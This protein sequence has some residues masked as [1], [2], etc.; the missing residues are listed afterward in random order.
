M[1]EHAQTRAG[2]INFSMDNPASPATTPITLDAR[3]V[4][5]TMLDHLG[6]QTKVD[7][8]TQDDAPLLHI[9]TADPDRLIGRNGQTLDQLQFLL[10]RILQR[11]NPDAPRVIVDCERYRERERDELIKKAL[12][13]VDR[14]R[15]WGDSVTI[16][17]YS[18]FDRRI[19][20]RHIERDPELEAVSEG[21]EDEGGRKRMIIRAKSK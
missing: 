2:K 17:P 3:I 16:G 15:R 13:A 10:N 1:V 21:N 4:L 6:L 19:I 9:A 12:D 5:Q 14:V 7:Q 20:H 8:F 18:P 11:A